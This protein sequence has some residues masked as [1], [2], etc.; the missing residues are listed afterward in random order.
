[1]TPHALPK[2]SCVLSSHR[3]RD[4]LGT[5]NTRDAQQERRAVHLSC[6]LRGKLPRLLPS[7]HRRKVLSWYVV[8]FGSFP[9][10]RRES[11]ARGAQAGAGCWLGSSALSLNVTVTPR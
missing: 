11:A 2:D 9:R 7:R 3:R 1:M 5:G 6:L 8:P 10:E 4:H